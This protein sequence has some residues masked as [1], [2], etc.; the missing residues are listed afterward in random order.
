MIA[1]LDLAGGLAGD[2]F[3]AACLGVGSPDLTPE[4]LTEVL[5]ALP[6]EGWRLETDKVRL[7]GLA[8]SRINFKVPEASVH[9]TWGLIRDEIIGPAELP[10]QTKTLALAAFE[11]LARAE[12]QVH[13]RAVDEVHFHEVGAD[14]SIL[15]IVGAAACLELLGVDRLTASPVPLSR[16]LGHCRHGA[17]PLPA[18]AT[19]NLLKGAKVFGTDNPTELITP[20]GAAILGWADEFGPMPAMELAG[21]GGGVG[22]RMPPEAPTRIFIGRTE[23][24]VG[25]HARNV[26]VLTTSIDDTTAEMAGPLME[27][28]LS[29]GGLDVV[30]SPVQMKKNRP[31]FRLEVLCDPEKAGILANH[32]LEQT[33]SLGVRYRQEKRLCLERRPGLVRLELPE[34]TPVEG[35]WGQK[36]SGRWEF[37]PEYESA[38]R[39][40]LASGRALTEIYRLAEAAALNQSPS[41]N[42]S[43]EDLEI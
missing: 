7:H 14:D 34:D 28:L 17:M 30:F 2:I 32:I 25:I 9:R 6:L 3:I 13:D 24:T 10:K 23:A 39:A 11:T 35:K 29:L 1:Y 12:A 16:G 43:G 15:D 27:D 41:S 22:S 38:R 40:A 42:P 20:T 19:V 31:G 18:P 37:R 36:P 21:V 26:T 5:K 8:L 4:K 33:S